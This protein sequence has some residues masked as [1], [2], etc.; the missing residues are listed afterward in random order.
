MGGHGQKWVWPFRIRG[1]KICCV[2]WMNRQVELMFCMLIEIQESVITGWVWESMC[3]VCYLKNEL[4]TWAEFLP[5][6]TDSAKLKFNS[7]WV[8]VVKYGCDLLGHWTWNLLY[9]KNKLMNWAEF[10]HAGSDVIIFWLG[11]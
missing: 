5:F 4:I 3:M 10:L 7:Y 6:H 8:S 11:C 2:Q 1:S 9:L